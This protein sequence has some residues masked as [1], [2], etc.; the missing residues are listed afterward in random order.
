MKIY[1]ASSWKNVHAVTMLTEKL[2]AAEH[3]VFSFV[4]NNHGE[5]MT[6]SQL[7]DED[8][9]PVSFDDW[10]A[11]P[12]GEKAYDYDTESAMGAD[13]VVYIGP[14]GK[15]AAYETGLARGRGVPAFGLLAKGEDFG[16]MRRGISWCRDVD[17]L[18]MQISILKLD[19]KQGINPDAPIH[20][21]R[22]DLPWQISHAD[23]GPRTKNNVEF[24]ARSYFGEGVLITYETATT[25]PTQMH[26]THRFPIDEF[27]EKC[28]RF[29]LHLERDESF[30]EEKRK[31]DAEETAVDLPVADTDHA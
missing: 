21:G 5:D 12:A 10:C 17:T 15:D 2:R 14:S 28:R 22:V 25:F 8:G 4:E 18:M 13:C 26:I 19:D 29:L 6:D 11:S 9:K 16:L 1:I 24:L 7:Y 30:A 3:E 20:F 23:F 27:D 31:A